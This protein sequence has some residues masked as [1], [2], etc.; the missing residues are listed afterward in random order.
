GRDVSQLRQVAAKQLNCPH[1]GGQLELRAPDRTERVGCPHCGSLLDASQGDL[2]LL[3]ALDQAKLHPVLPLGAV[4]K[5]GA[6]ERTVIGLIRRS[7]TF[8]RVDYF[9]DEYL[10]YHPRAGFEWLVQS[11]SEERRVG[12]GCGWGRAA[13]QCVGCCSG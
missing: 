8:E 10:L 3:T 12:K 5:F 13:E 1:C 6:E 9:W 2:R 4:G 11:R 7:V